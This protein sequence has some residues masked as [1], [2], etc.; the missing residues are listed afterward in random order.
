VLEVV[1]RCEE[2][3]FHIMPK[4]WIVERTFLWFLAYRRLSKDYEVKTEI[5]KSMI[6]LGM[7]RRI[8]KNLT[9]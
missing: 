5:S 2:A 4:R 3:G 6:F 8:L 7:I 1:E 9:K